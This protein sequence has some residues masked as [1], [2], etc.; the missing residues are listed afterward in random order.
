MSS[1][2]LCAKVKVRKGR[3]RK[4][5]IYMNYKDIIMVNEMVQWVKQLTA[6]SKELNSICKA[7]VEEGE[8]QV[9]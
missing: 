6:T 7:H 5:R 3:G 1:H 8:N 4:L 9:P 2:S